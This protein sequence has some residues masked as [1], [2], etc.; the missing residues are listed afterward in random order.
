[1]PSRKLYPVQ[2]K[3]SVIQPAPLAPTLAI[4]ADKLLGQVNHRLYRESR[5]YECKVS[6]DANVAD[7]V[8]VDVYALANTWYLQGAVKTAKMVWDHAVANAIEAN[9]GRTARWS[10]FK[11]RTGI[12][13]AGE[14]FAEQYVSGT[15]TGATF[16]SG[17]FYDTIVEDASGV[18]HNFT[19]GAGTASQYNIFDEYDKQSGTSADPADPSTGPYSGLLPNLSQINSDSVTDDGN[20]PPYSA[21]GYGTAI[22][23]KVGTL[24]LAAGRQKLSTGFFEAPLGKI[25]L[26]GV[27]TLTEADIQLEVKSG[28]YKGVVA[29]NMLE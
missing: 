28:D 12:P 25:V 8:T 21:A 14:G 13:T 26:T 29:H 15:L 24:H 23:V 11:I 22:W 19:L 27:G 16:T 9:D 3:I 20:L 17:E 4:Q 6:I 1:M 18:A 5:V 7:G 10:D 2:R